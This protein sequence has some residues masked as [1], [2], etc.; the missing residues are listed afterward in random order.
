MGAAVRKAGHPDSVQG[1]ERTHFYWLPW[2]SVNC[3]HCFIL[4]T[5][6]AKFTLYNFIF[7]FPSIFLILYTLCNTIHAVQC[8]SSP[9]GR[10]YNASTRSPR[11]GQTPIP[12][13][14]THLVDFVIPMDHRV[15]KKRKENDK[16]IFEP[17]QGTKNLWNMS[18]TVIPIV[19]GVLVTGPTNLDKGSRNWKW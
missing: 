8:P 3:K 13:P 4:A 11:K 2:K 12:P 7:L 15:K 19:I 16:Q 9:V 17:R 1:H 6:K 14:N 18:V 10:S 5:S